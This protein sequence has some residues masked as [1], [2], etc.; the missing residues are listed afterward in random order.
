MHWRISIVGVLAL[1][2]ALSCNQQP[3]E[4]QQDN[5]DPALSKVVF[6][7]WIEPLSAAG[8]VDWVAC[9]DD[10]AG[11]WV[12]WSGFVNVHW[13]SRTTPSGNEV[14]TCKFDY[15]T[16]TPFSFV[17]LSSDDEYSL[18]T[19]HDNCRIITKPE[20][21]ELFLSFQANEKYI[22]QDDEKVHFRN[23]WRL[24]IDADGEVKIDRFVLEY[25]CPGNP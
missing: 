6:D 4:P 25:K 3:V 14:L 9:A 8:V 13:F 11:E 12:E 21:P 18:T 5:V 22:N 1:F 17:G 7:R 10:G 24:M 15:D 2:V 23:S 20:G 16:A 19:G